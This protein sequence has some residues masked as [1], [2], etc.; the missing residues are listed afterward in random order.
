[1]NGDSLLYGCIYRSPAKDRTESTKNVCDIISEAVHRNNSHLLICG[2]FNYPGI[3][4][5]CDYVGDSPNT[6]AAFIE[7]IQEC[8]L[9]QHIFEPTRF[10]DG[11]EPG[12]LDLVL[13][14]EEGMVYNLTHKSG[15]DES[16]HTCIT[17]TLKCY[18]KIKDHKEVPNYFKAD[19]ETI[20]ERLSKVNWISKLDSDFERSYDNF[21]KVLKSTMEGC[22]PY[23]KS[24]K[25]RKNI[26]LTQEAIRKKNLK[27]KLWR[28]YTRERTHFNRK[29]YNQAKNELRS[30]TRKLRE[31]FEMRIAQNIKI[32]PKSFWSY[33]KS[34]TKTRAKIPP[35]KK[36][37]DTE[38]VTA[39]DKAETLN[40]YFSSSFTDERLDDVPSN[41]ETTYLSI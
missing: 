10:R 6:T 26:Y 14:N 8:Y 40:I 11:H 36:A 17:F 39:Y 25:K 20:R 7:T 3:D 38:A 31:Q 27:N 33:V 13:S 22:I 24:A 18:E 9:Y 35:L 12:L 5:E 41:S 23:Y 21:I 28:R 4:W 34:K 37:D 2:D 29:K 16:D 32:S 30:L 15:L 1:M 19:Y